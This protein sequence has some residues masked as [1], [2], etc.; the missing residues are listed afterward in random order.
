[1]EN[2]PQ[3]IF[4]KFSPN[5]RRIL[6]SAQ[7]IAQSMDSA[8][9]SEHILLA[10]AVTPN[11]LANGIL[12][13]NMVGM[14][15]IRLT[16]SLNNFRHEA[17]GMTEEAKDILEIAAQKAS[18]FSHHQIDTEHLLLAI[19]SNPSSLAADIISRIGA[20]PE[21]IKTQIENIFTDLNDYTEHA[22]ETKD[23]EN[24]LSG[25]DQI[26]NSD[27]FNEPIQ[28]MDFPGGQMSMSPNQ[29][30]AVENFAYDLTAQAKEGKIDPLIGREKELERV[31]QILCRRTKNNPVLVGESG[32]GKTAIVE[33]LAQKIIEGTVPQK[34]ADKKL[35]MLDLGLLVAGTMYRG[36]FED[37][38]K[39]FLDELTKKGDAIL[40]ID[41]LHTIVGTGSAEGS[42][43]LANILKPSLSK[44]KI[45][46]IGATT[47]DEYRKFIE[48]DPALERRLQKVTVL[49]PSDID[50]IAILKGIRKNYEAHHQVKITDE[51]I[52]AAVE[53]SK[54]YI[55]DRN[56]PDKAI[57]LIDEAA[58][59]WQIKHEIKDVSELDNLKKQLNKI[60]NQKNQEA[61]NQN[62][63]KA[64]YLRTLEIKV[65]SQIEKTKGKNIKKT[66]LQDAAIYR[67]DITK[68]LAL[69][70]NVPVEKLQTQE[71]TK[72][73]NLDKSLKKYIIG[74]DEAIKNITKAI[75]RSKTGLSDPNRPIGSFIFLG[76]TG[77]G[78]TEL[79]KVLAQELF[80]SREALIKIDMSEFM[81]RH[82]VSRLVGAPPGYVGYDEAGKLTEQVR[83]KPYS[84]IL[85]DEIEKASPDVFNILLQILEDGEL[86]D[87]KG[88]RVNFR[89]TIII[90]TSNIGMHKLNEQAII[91]FSGMKN[92]K[93]ISNDYEKMKDEVIKDLKGEFRPELLNRLD[94]IIVFKPL[95]K[96]EIIEITKLQLL[97]LVQRMQLEKINLQFNNDVIKFI[98]EKGYDPKFGARPIRR[99]ISEEIEDPLS[100]A[101]LSGKFATDNTIKVNILNNKI[102]FVLAIKKASHLAKKVL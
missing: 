91:G 49:E 68:V 73:L 24:T 45:H 34:I 79:A 62:F 27:S 74:Q 35:I 95:S 55:F 102:T 10:L 58:A 86:S 96:K 52:I 8:L 80:G 36:Q 77:V 28:P 61:Q 12:K 81:E 7:K 76:P 56:L 51:A 47:S 19:V 65:Q 82:N 71:K 25:F 38:I 72:F 94:K 54:R 30:K 48:K 85:F 57:D 41:E 14:D 92:S 98:A 97:N 20:S 13:E 39:K 9:G 90:M 5:A 22:K 78:K 70:T 4:G 15:Q 50:T 69:W 84:L 100:E 99:A 46:L 3:D 16:I 32:V 53:L 31:I 42:Q 83:Q 101:I 60:R 33:G 59:A 67:D 93:S 63:E 40:F 23:S 89:N 87:A 88:K 18:Q 2:D 66:K 44:G 64:A 29:G 75:Q 26:M 11:T 21:K 1:M 6:I 43:D 37:R 17:I